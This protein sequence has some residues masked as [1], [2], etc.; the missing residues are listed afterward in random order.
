MI[1]KRSHVKL[2]LPGMDTQDGYR[3]LFRQISRSSPVS[4][5]PGNEKRSILK[6]FFLL[7]D[8]THEKDSPRKESHWSRS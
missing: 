5:L 2:T 7:F 3:S 8:L 4:P 1:T 6:L